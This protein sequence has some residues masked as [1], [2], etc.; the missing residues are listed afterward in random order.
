MISK[1]HTLF[2]RQRLESLTGE[3]ACL[4]AENSNP[5][6]EIQ[7]TRQEIQ[8][9]R[10]ESQRLQQGVERLAKLL[11]ESG[12][13][14]PPTFVKV[15]AP[16]KERRPCGKRAAQHNHGWR[17]M[18]PTQH[19]QHPIETCPTCGETLS[20]RGCHY[21]RAVIDIPASQSVGVVEHQIMRGWCRHCRR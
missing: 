14:K 7:L 12:V 3:V 9:V 20:A 19:R 16:V 13:N 18:K 1:K 4:S 5:R 10:A 15:N 8:T 2:T 11:E 17:R 6:C 21:T